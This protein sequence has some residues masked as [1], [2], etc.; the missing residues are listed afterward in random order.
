MNVDGIFCDL[1]RDFDCVNQKRLLTKLHFF[2][3]FGIQG[4]KASWF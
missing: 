3:F 1:T 4:A 2:F